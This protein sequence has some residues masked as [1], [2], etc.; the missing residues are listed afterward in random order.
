MARRG[1][2]REQRHVER[3]PAR[4]RWLSWVPEGLIV[5][6]VI[7]AF[8]N[9]EYDLAHRWLGL[10][11]VNPSTH[12]GDVLPPEGLDLVAGGPAAPV[13]PALAGAPVD[14]AAIKAAL[15]PYAGDARLGKHLAFQVADVR[16]GEVAFSR[17]AEVVVPAS[18]LKILTGAA[19][20]ESLGPA[21]RFTTR[22]VAS[23]TGVVLVGGGDPFLASGP[24]KAKDLYPTRA[25]LTTLA[26]RTAVAL[27]A[28][29]LSAVTLAYDD[30][31]F[32][33]PAVNPRWPA[34]YLPDDVVPPITALW[35]DEGK[36]PDGRY[37]A[38]PSV[39]AA[40]IFAAALRKV[41]I[42]V[43]GP[44]AGTA[45]LGAEELAAVQSAP[46]GEI[47]Q[48]VLQVS[49]NN[50]AEVLARHVALA[51]GKKGS[52][53]S[54][55]AAILQVLAS[56]G[57]DVSGAKVYDG[58]GLSRDNRLPA[59]LLLEVLSAAASSEYPRLREVITGLPVAGF[60]GSLR[61]RFDTGKAEGRGLVRAK[62]GTLTGVHGLAG[63]AADQNG[64]LMAFVLVTDQ[65]AVPN[66]LPVRNLLDQ[67]AGALGACRCGA[68]PARNDGGDGLV[69]S[70]H[71]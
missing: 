23:A 21:A 35:A 38:A 58:S 5:L 63:I 64:A 47:V 20:L 40:T 66:T 18:T 29:G 57:M 31:L 15:A 54:G 45:P 69:G 2:R 8:G 17:G 28:R 62:T 9:V 44:R 27:K 61:N 39:S 60:T 11:T 67:M 59:S 25:D 68:T 6:V 36:G 37:V 65:V 3:S 7:A 49:D 19:A 30:G 12:P 53:I 48:Q 42:T 13:A 33:G 32:S 50:A 14:P 10:E 41:G 55:S 4:S 22:V 70:S 46:V 26:R 24:G 43:T 52:F 34:N 16:T 51:L 56:L 71:D 1:A